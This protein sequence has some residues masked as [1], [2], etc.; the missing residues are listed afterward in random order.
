MESCSIFYIYDYFKLIS[1]LLMCGLTDK[2]KC[3]YF[4]IWFQTFQMGKG[5]E[6]RKSF[7]QFKQS[8]N[9]WIC[10]A[11]WSKYSLSLSRDINQ[12]MLLCWR[13][14]CQRAYGR[15]VTLRPTASIKFDWN[16]PVAWEVQRELML[17][18]SIYSFVKHNHMNLISLGNFPWEIRV[19]II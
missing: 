12:D 10:A 8:V 6:G 14:H 4:S 2:G 19:K 1:S 9:L 16:R 3:V 18:M 17:L 15:L 13:A 7:S 11:E 5:E